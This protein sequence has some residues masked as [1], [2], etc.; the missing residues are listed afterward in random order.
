MNFGE[1]IKR[2]R[3][4]EEMTQEQFAEKLSVT[5]QA[6]SN[7]ENNKNLPDIGMLILISDVFHVSLDILIKGEENH[8]NN[9]TEKVIRDGSETRRARY[10]MISTVISGV[11]L[12]MGIMCF[13]IKACSVEYIDTEGF[14]HE[15]FFLI[16]IGSLFVFCGIVSFM[17]IGIRTIVTKIKERR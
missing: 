9:M 13:W 15:N 17:S 5:R 8:M 11:L 10:N 12:L 16:P 14:L 4:E 2:I 1:E 7:W 6:I 3:Q